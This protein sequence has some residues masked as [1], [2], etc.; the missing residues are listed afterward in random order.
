MSAAKDAGLQAQNHR[1]RQAK[2]AET[3]AVRL[4]DRSA[5]V[6]LNRIPHAD[7]TE[8]KLVKFIAEHPTLTNLD[9]SHNDTSDLCSLLV[10]TAVEKCPRIKALNLSFNR[11]GDN[12]CK[13]LA[14]YVELIVRPSFTLCICVF[15]ISLNFCSFGLYYICSIYNESNACVPFVFVVCVFVCVC[16]CVFVNCVR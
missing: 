10:A 9:L 6:R 15:G 16:V 7:W 11:L 13:V 12:F 5:V 2:A 4:L 1:E 14:R 8:P 3:I